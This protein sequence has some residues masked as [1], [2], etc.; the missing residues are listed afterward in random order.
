VLAPGCTYPIQVKDNGSALGENGL[1]VI[2]KIL[3]IRGDHANATITRTTVPTPTTA[4]KFRI[5]EVASGG[6]LTLDRI[7]VDNGDADDGGAAAPDKFRK[8]R[9][10]G[11]YNHGILRVTNSTLSNNRASIGGGGVGNGDPQ[12]VCQDQPSSCQPASGDLR[13]TEDNIVTDNTAGQNGAGIANGATSAMN[14]TRCAISENIGDPT[15]GGGGIASQG[16]ADLTRCTIRNNKAPDGAGIINIGTMS[17][18]DSPVTGNTARDAGGGILN[19]NEGGIAGNVTLTRS[20][21]TENKAGQDGGGIIN[22]AG[23]TVS[24]SGSQVAKNAAGND[25][26]GIANGGSITLTQSDVKGNQAGR[27]GGGIANDG[28]VTLNHS[29]ITGNTPNNCSGATVPGC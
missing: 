24:L 22:Q 10:G 25:F 6:D 4:P 2:N 20:D 18:T 21:V 28:T 17:L 7:T 26:A 8:G 11:I 9:G 23:G 3:T 14:L 19:V 13:L 12:E 27:D 1:P 5:L 16:N 15:S 29:K